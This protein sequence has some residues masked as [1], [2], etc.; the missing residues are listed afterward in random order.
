MEAIQRF[1]Y[2]LEYTDPK[3]QDSYRYVANKFPD[4]YKDIEKDELRENN[5]LIGLI[6]VSVLQIIYFIKVCFLPGPTEIYP[7]SA[8]IN[9]SSNST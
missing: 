7:I 8:P 1:I 6:L 4:N 9:S 5:P 2:Y 3:I